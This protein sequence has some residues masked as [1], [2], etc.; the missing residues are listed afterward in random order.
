MANKV[1]PI[2]KTLLKPGIVAAVRRKLLLRAGELEISVEITAEARPLRTGS[3]VPSQT[4][5]KVLPIR[6]L[7]VRERSDDSRN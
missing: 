4:Q 1:I 6:Q 5:S 2:R 3:A 7:G